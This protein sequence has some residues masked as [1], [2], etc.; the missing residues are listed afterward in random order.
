MTTRTVYGR[1]PTCGAPG[2]L[3]ER[4]INGNDKCSGGHVYPSASA[5]Q[6]A[7]AVLPMTE[8]EK[9]ANWLVDVEWTDKSQSIVPIIARALDAA[10]KRG[11]DECY[12][13]MVNEQKAQGLRY[14][15]HEIPKH[16]ENAWSE[17]AIRPAAPEGH[18]LDDAGVVRKE[19]GA[20]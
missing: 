2:V 12:A 6:D 19:R 8:N 7:P 10:E 3:R 1:C 11:A 15:K 18:I 4:R 5:I 17:F 20:Q 16:P 14:V 13:A 9:R